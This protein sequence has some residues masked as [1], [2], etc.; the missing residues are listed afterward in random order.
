MYTQVLDLFTSK[1]HLAEPS[2]RTHLGVLVEFIGMWERFLTGDL[3]HEVV[4]R[5]GADE[6]NLEAFYADLND[7]FERLQSALKE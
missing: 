7:N 3:P 4:S 6:G 1:M 2:T 5:I